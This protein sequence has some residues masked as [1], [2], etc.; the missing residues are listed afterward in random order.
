M[1]RLISLFMVLPACAKSDDMSGTYDADI[2]ALNETCHT[3]TGQ[4]RRNT[5]CVPGADSSQ[6]M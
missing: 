3:K 1:P 5:G 4:S 6:V 2:N